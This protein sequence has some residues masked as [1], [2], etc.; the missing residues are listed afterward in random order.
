VLV[1]NT[2]SYVQQ[3]RKLVVAGGEGPQRKFVSSWKNGL[4]KNYWTYLK[5]KNCAPLSNVSAGPPLIAPEPVTQTLSCKL[6]LIEPLELCLFLKHSH[7]VALICNIASHISKQQINV[8][9][10]RLLAYL[11]STIGQN[12]ARN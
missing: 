4:G 9:F 5:K 3:A 8:H 1:T 7:T 6:N 2:Q 10:Q 12:P 11:R